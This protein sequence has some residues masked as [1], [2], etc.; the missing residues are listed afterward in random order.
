[1]INLVEHVLVPGER[2]RRLRQI[3]PQMPE[4]GNDVLGLSIQ[5]RPLKGLSLNGSSVSPAGATTN[6]ERER[7]LHRAVT[8]TRTHTLTI[9]LPLIITW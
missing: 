4:A 7:R 6:E 5:G 2:G 1:M 9:P 3:H 8:R